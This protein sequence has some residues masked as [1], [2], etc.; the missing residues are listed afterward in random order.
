MNRWLIHGLD[1]I[2][3]ISNEF[4][5]IYLIL[6]IRGFCEKVL[7]FWLKIIVFMIFSVDKCFYGIN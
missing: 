1:D 5:I 4:L 6:L 7:I 2:L 3:F